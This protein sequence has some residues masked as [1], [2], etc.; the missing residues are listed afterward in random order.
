MQ[1]QMAQGI[2]FVLITM[3]LLCCWSLYAGERFKFWQ[4]Y[5]DSDQ[6]VI[7]VVNY[8]GSSLYCWIDVEKGH[9]SDFEV[10]PIS[11]SNDYFEPKSNYETGCE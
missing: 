3:L 9:Y 4:R 7:W 5:N 10:A 2:K 6:S 8:S 11:R 1:S